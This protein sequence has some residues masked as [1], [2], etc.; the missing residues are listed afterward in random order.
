MRYFNYII[1]VSL[2]R[3]IIYLKTGSFGEKELLPD[4]FILGFLFISYGVPFGF[5]GCIVCLM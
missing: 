1:C 3:R 2:N 4:F 5:I